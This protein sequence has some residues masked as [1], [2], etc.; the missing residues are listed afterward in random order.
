MNTPSIVKYSGAF[1][2][3]QFVEAYESVVCLDSTFTQVTLPIEEV[4]HVKNLPWKIQK[5]QKFAKLPSGR[6]LNVTTGKLVEAKDAPSFG[7]D[8]THNPARFT[9]TADAERYVQRADRTL[10][11]SEAKARPAVTA[12]L[13]APGPVES[14]V[15]Y[16]PP[17]AAPALKFPCLV[18]AF[19]RKHYAYGLNKD[20][21][22][23]LF[24]WS[25][26]QLGKLKATVFAKDFG[27]VKL[28]GKIQVQEKNGVKFFQIPVISEGRNVIVSMATGNVITDKKIVGLFP[29]EV[30]NIY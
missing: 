11:V 8:G 27:V 23:K 3:A 7:G 14:L 19:G 5:G 29:T 18:E 16:K 22:V 21:S 15:A 9:T 28:T 13:D 17:K 26:G 24:G 30:V 2:V 6:V 4:T 12:H 20:G 10:K 25:N 1:Y